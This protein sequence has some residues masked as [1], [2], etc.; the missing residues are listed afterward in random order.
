MATPRS[1]RMRIAYALSAVIFASAASIV[2]C[3][4]IVG[5]QDVKLRRDSGSGADVGDDEVDIFR[6][7]IVTFVS[8]SG[9]QGG[10]TDADA[11]TKS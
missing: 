2:A 6:R 10:Y 3:A 7:P 8:A 9:G 11:S 1:K 5:V 4:S